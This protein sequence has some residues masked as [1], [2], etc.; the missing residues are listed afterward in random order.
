MKLIITFFCSL[1]SILTYADNTIIGK[2]K[3]VPG[4]EQ[5]YTVQWTTWDNLYEDYA[6]VSWQVTNGTVIESDKHSVTIRWNEMPKWLNE[7]GV[8]EVSEDLGGAS[9]MLTVDIFNFIAATTEACSGILGA[10]VIYQDFGS[11]ANPGP[12]MPAGTITYQYQNYCSIVPGEYTRVNST[13][14]CRSS[15]LGIPQD[16]T[17]N[18]INGYM[19]MVDGDEKRGEIFRTSVSGNLTT[20]FKYE[21]SAW[22]ASLSDIGEDPRIHFE[23][24][25]MNGNLIRQSGVYEITFNA[26]SPWQRVSVMFDLPI[27]TTAL[28]V[29]MVNNNNDYSGNDFVVDDLSFAPCYTPIIASFSATDIIDRSSVC[30]SGSINLYS[31]WPTP[32]LPFTNPSYKWQRSTDNGNIWIDIPGATTI[33]S[34]I[35]ENVPGMYRYRVYAFETTDPTQFVVSNELKYFVQ[36]MKVEPLS[37]NVFSCNTNPVQISP[38]YMLEYADPDGPP[39]S[40]TFTWSPGT[41]LSNANIERPFI[42]LPPLAPPINNASPPPPISY[43]YNLSVQNVEYGC[44]GS[45]V[46]TV[47]QYNPRKVLVPSAFTPDGDGINDLFRPLN[48]QDYPGGKFWVYNRWGQIV[49]YS[50]GPSLLD[51]SWNGTFQGNPQESGTY[52]WRVYIPGCGNNIAS[53]SYSNTNPYGTVL[54][55]R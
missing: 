27:G 29:I 18:D 53:G 13:V 2:L 28:T 36:R 26:S 38:I 10:P 55:I 37:Y 44:V 50:E 41:Y 31:R 1:I 15:W 6:N 8:I 5:V 39:L 12:P 40:F 4:E 35:S 24:W 19:L 16:H 54:L 3:V 43:T 46:Q 45:A 52:T 9:G 30:N 17:P 7:S 22:V 25:D 49:F 23:L 48:L 11:G 47:L 42:S 32:T 34:A 33:N 20:A 21:F 51:Y 14:N